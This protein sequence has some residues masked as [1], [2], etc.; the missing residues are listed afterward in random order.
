VLGRVSS[1]AAAGRSSLHL[2]IF[3][4]GCIY[5]H[6]GKDFL[7]THSLMV[8]PANFRL[9]QASGRVFPAMAVARGDTASVIA[10]TGLL[11]V[12]SSPSSEQAS[13]VADMKVPSGLSAAA[14]S[15][16]KAA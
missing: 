10:G 2:E 9:V 5:D 14:L 1:E 11:P 12:S 7:Q 13:A 3:I 6:F 15:A 8:D 4:S 16:G